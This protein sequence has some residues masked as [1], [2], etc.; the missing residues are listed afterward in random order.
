MLLTVEDWSMLLGACTQKE[1]KKNTAEE[2]E[3]LV[4][5]WRSSRYRPTAD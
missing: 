2:E 3:G 5:T 1:R 4:D